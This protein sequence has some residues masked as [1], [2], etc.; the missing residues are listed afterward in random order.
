MATA[1]LR[2]HGAAVCR[3][4]GVAPLR[5]TRLGS[6]RRCLGRC[7]RSE[8][9]THG[10]SLSL[11]LPFSLCLSL[12]LSPFLCLSLCLSLSLSA[13]RGRAGGSGAGGERG[14]QAHAVEPASSRSPPGAPPPA[15]A[16]Q[17]APLLGRLAWDRFR[18]TSPLD[19]PRWTGPGRPVQHLTTRASSCA[20][21]PM[22]GTRGRAWYWCRGGGVV[23][24]GAGGGGR[25]R[26]GHGA[27]AEAAVRCEEGRGAKGWTLLPALLRLPRAR[28]PLLG[29]FAPGR[30]RL[31]ISFD[32]SGCCGPGTTGAAGPGA[33]AR[34]GRRQ[35]GQQGARR[36]G[37]LLSDRGREGEGGRGR[38][39]EGGR[40]GGRERDFLP[41]RIRPHPAERESGT[42]LSRPPLFD[43]CSAGLNLTASV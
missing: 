17:V 27:G 31:T 18:L 43:R 11:F 34:T 41:V 42:F 32:R 21:T 39:G 9:R 8:S 2:A 19:R 26:R 35:R 30:F 33:G 24:G 15:A 3:G 36:A 13:F 25:A 22:R 16:F 23:R 7:C 38:E 37:T 6:E 20:G 5:R 29:R 4:R 14:A 12:F 10:A 40:E 28:P 1:P